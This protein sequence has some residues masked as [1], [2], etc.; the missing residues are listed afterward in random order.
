MVEGLTFRSKFVALQNSQGIVAL[1]YKLQ[2]FSVHIDGHHNNHTPSSH[3]HIKL[4]HP[5]KLLP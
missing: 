2:M 5:V 3:E 4:K 1:W